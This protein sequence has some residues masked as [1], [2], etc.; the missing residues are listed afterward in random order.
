MADFDLNLLRP[1]DA[2]LETRSVTEAARRIGVSQPTMSGMLARLRER[3][4]D[5]LLVR[6]GRHMELTSRA[7][8]LAPEVRQALL[9]ATQAMRPVTDFDPA[10]L[11]RTFRIMTSEFGLFLILPVVFRRAESMAPNLRFETVLIDQPA[12]SVYT[13]SVDL[14]LTGDIL[15]QVAGEMAAMVRTQTLMEEHFVGIVDE[16]HPLTGAVTLDELLAYPHVAT[17]FP[18]SPWTVEDIGVSGM[19][20]RHPP[21]VRVASFLALGRLVA[22]TRAIGVVPAQLA[23]L[24]QTGDT[25]RTLSL[26]DDFDTIAIRQL[27]HARHDQDPAHRWLRALVAEACAEVRR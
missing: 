7:E 22:G 20:D 12:A 8:T 16:T 11:A 3:M 5:P 27:W 17:Q 4:S 21:R 26:P 1:L 13:G 18:G 23:G 24:M 10:T 9:A 2:L 14:C 15:G 19:S 6:V 25:L